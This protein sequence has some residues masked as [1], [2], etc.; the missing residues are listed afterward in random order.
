MPGGSVAQYRYDALGRRIEKDVDGVIT[1]YVY[2]SEDILLEFEGTNTQIAR[3]THG[4]GIDEP[5][6]MARG[7]QSFFYQADGLGSIIDLTDINGSVV[8][9]YVYD[10]FGN[11]EQQVG[12]IVN[13]YTYTGREID[14]ESG[15]YFYRARYYDSIMGRF[16]NEDPI[17]F[18]AGDNNFYRYVQN[19]PV[20]F[21]DPYG[22]ILG[23]SDPL[24]SEGLIGLGVV[25]AIVGRQPLIG[26]ALIVTG[27]Y[28][29]V[30]TPI[31]DNIIQKPLE[32][33]ITEIGNKR[34][35]DISELLD[36]DE[37]DREKGK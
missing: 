17:G 26:T 12:N 24:I 21:V 4:P 20:N 23:F 14:I 10:S 33:T 28:I 3:Y 25:V 35:N 6:I 31:A 30:T 16:I 32:N 2:D 8:Q 37:D 9:R 7:G 19:N 15:L 11:I 34:A 18:V 36:L 5:L 13:P 1:R 22:Y 29:G 27:V